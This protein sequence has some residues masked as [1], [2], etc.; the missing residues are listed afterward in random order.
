[1]SGLLVSFFSLLCFLL[2]DLLIIFSFFF[3]IRLC[4]KV[5]G[6][7]VPEPPTAFPTNASWD[8][9]RDHCVAEHAAACADVARLHPAEVYELRRCVMMK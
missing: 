3:P 2:F 7:S 4:Q 9:L 8:T 1:M 6:K 5:E